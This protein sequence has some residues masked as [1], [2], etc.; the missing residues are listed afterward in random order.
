[1]NTQN[2][3]IEIQVITGDAVHASTAYTSE[4]S[5][6]GGG[7]N[8]FGRTDP[9]RIST[10]TRRY[11]RIHLRELT[12]NERVLEVRDVAISVREG[13]R[14]SY[15][16]GVLPG[17]TRGWYIGVYNHDTRTY[18]T[19]RDGIGRLCPLWVRAMASF[20]VG[21]VSLA[22]WTADRW[23]LGFF[24]AVLGAVAAYRT[25]SPTLAQRAQL[26]IAARASVGAT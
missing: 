1:M 5:G 26:D 11:D 2:E 20:G 9:V 24:W 12:G 19:L 22:Q 6:R 23:G 17:E 8:L 15:L 13:N 7:T 25:L 14:L 3:Q 18:Y 21:M 10:K 4:V 16:L